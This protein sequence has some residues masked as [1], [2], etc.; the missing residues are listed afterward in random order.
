[1]R[2]IHTIGFLSLQRGIY[3]FAHIIL[4]RQRLTC[5]SYG[6]M[7]TNV[8]GRIIMTWSVHSKHTGFQNLSVTRDVAEE[9]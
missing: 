9:G 1:M 8:G 2:L 3:S 7:S 6:V 5:I 4:K